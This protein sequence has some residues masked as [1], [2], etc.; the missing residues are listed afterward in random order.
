MAPVL[1]IVREADG[2]GVFTV[3]YVELVHLAEFG[4]SAPRARPRSR[5]SSPSRKRLAEARHHEAALRKLRVARH[6]LVRRAVETMC[7]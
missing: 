7:S 6:A 5:P 2:I 1:Q 4:G 3:K